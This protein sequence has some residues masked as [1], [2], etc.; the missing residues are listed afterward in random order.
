MAH[1]GMNKLRQV[2]KIGLI[3]LCVVML[4]TLGVSVSPFE[5]CGEGDQT[6]ATL[7][8]EGDEVEITPLEYQNYVR[9]PVFQ[10][11]FTFDPVFSAFAGPGRVMPE[12]PPWRFLTIGDPM[13]Q[14]YETDED[15]LW[16]FV[17]L[18][19]KADR[20]G[21]E[22]SPD[23]VG[24]WL[25]NHP[26][27][28]NEAG[29]FDGEAYR[30]QVGQYF[31]TV[32]AFEALA[33]RYLRVKY[34]LSHY[35]GL[36]RPTQQEVYDTWKSRNQ[37]HDFLYVVQD[38]KPL[39][40]EIDPASFTE[41]ELQAF[42]A[43][44]DVADDFH[45][46]TY[47][48]FEV[49]YL[50]PKS[51][52]D[53][54]YASIVEKAKELSIHPEPERARQYYIANSKRLYPRDRLV[55][56]LREE[57]EESR[58]TE[59]APGGSDESD[60][61]A[62]DEG[63]T[64]PE[65]EAPVDDGDEAP[66]DEGDEEAPA[67]PDDSSEEAGAAG[68]E[69]KPADAPPAEETFADPT[70]GMDEM[71]IYEKYFRTQVER[72]HFVREVLG[73]ILADERIHRLG[74]AEVAEAWGLSY[75]KTDAPMDEIGIRGASPVGGY[76]LADA[77][78]TATPAE[79][80]E[81]A[82]GK[83]AEEI[84]EVG[85]GDET[86]RG[87]GFFRIV[88]VHPERD[89]ALGDRIPNDVYRRAIWNAVS[90]LPYDRIEE[91][92]I[93]DALRLAFPGA[94][95]PEKD[96]W[97]VADL[98]RLRLRQARAEDLAVERLTALKDRV[99]A[100][101]QTLAAAAEEMGY[102]VREFRGA[103]EDLTV[104]AEELPLPGQELDDAKKAANERLEHRRFLLKGASTASLR[105]N[106]DV[107]REATAE[108][109]LPE[110]LTNRRNRSAYLVYVRAHRMPGPEEMPAGDADRILSE[111][112]RSNRKPTI[113]YFFSWPEVSKRFQI[114][115]ADQVASR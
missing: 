43:R 17:A 49:A 84:V 109:F 41:E 37:R 104:P 92:T 26:R 68:D 40:E 108:S 69:E 8:I 105:R 33:A 77:I 59:D 14:E 51:L 62:P 27:F 78:R 13:W 76:R 4:G 47:W 34:Y 94:P 99:V 36:L 22:L 45:V 97:T 72:E 55:R 87:L 11:L 24:T 101:R 5:G 115:L 61:D 79:K 53:E 9:Y 52:S 80:P 30:D 64:P 70:L 19:L 88:E 32:S 106:L 3:V 12:R 35:I 18:D 46:P 96:E 44:E 113:R 95:I 73:R 66:V 81:E 89:P 39:M 31:G 2:E 86:G 90:H 112:L 48:D 6:I 16:T 20:A 23:A 63:G 93:G 83:Y 58:K 60:D 7:V 42:Y 71:E 21:I 82:A 54:A 103:Y 67:A 100:G 28:Q 65:D 85:D 110:I 50:Y 75:W 114:R 57:W 98:V 15:D 111:L 56:R 10:N 91:G 107:I 102:E 38:V 1:R 29:G 74:V 25:E